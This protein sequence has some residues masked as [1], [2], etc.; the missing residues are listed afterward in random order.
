MDVVFTSGPNKG[1]LECKRPA[2]ASANAENN[3]YANLQL[4]IEKF[5]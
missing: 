1:I 4:I 5:K 3:V 2:T